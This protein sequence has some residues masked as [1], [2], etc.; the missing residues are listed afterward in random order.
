MKKI[1]YISL[2]LISILIIAHVFTPIKIVH[3]GSTVTQIEDIIIEWITNEPSSKKAIVHV[4]TSE[5]NYDFLV[6]GNVEQ[7]GEETNINLDGYLF[8]EDGAQVYAQSVSISVFDYV[9]DLPL[10]FGEEV[11]VIHMHFDKVGALALA[12]ASVFVIAS[13]FHNIVEAIL[14]EVG[15]LDFLQTVN[16]SMLRAAIPW[17]YA[18]LYFSDHNPEDWSLDLYIP[19]FYHFPE[20]QLYIG[21]PF[22]WWLITKRWFIITYFTVDRKEPRVSVPTNAFICTDTISM[23]S[24]DASGN[25]GHIYAHTIPVR[26]PIHS[27]QPPIYS[28]SLGS[29][30][31]DNVYYEH[32]VQKKGVLALGLNTNII[33]QPAQT[34]TVETDKGT[35]DAYLPELQIGW[36]SGLVAALFYVA[37]DGSTYHSRSDHDYNYDTNGGEQPDLTPEQAMVPEHLARAGTLLPSASFAWSPDTPKPGETVTFHSTSFDPDGTI[38]RWHW[39]FGDGC[40]AQGETVTHSYSQ[41]GFYDVRL[42]VTDD[43]G[44][45]RETSTSIMGITFFV[46]PEASLGTISLILAMIGALGLFIAIHRPKRLNSKFKHLM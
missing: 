23:S 17:W 13:M 19:R 15:L 31:T 12:F 21:T 45:T 9:Y 34:V 26:G 20:N 14:E 43:D 25:S 7:L 32:W 1:R 30:G 6:E 4:I 41:T 35:I 16:W 22:Y 37:T 29:L 39:W 36:M 5:A 2:A 42:Q 3:A 28:L 46:I 40:E 11:E 8:L 38:V 44:S 10:A 24:T 33:I 18:T 27:L